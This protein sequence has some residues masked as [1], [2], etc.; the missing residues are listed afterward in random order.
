MVNSNQSGKKRKRGTLRSS[1][2]VATPLGEVQI[3]YSPTPPPIPAGKE[4]HPRRRLP[5]VPEGKDEPDPDP[6]PPTIIERPNPSP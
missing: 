5:P 3:T 1:E 6:S 2:V 4:I